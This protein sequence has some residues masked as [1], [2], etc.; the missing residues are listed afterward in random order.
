[1]ENQD[2]SARDAVEAARESN[3]EADDLLRDTGLFLAGIAVFLTLAKR[4]R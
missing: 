4:T 3:P 2:P 1:V